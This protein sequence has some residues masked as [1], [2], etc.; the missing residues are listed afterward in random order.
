MQTEEPDVLTSAFGEDSLFRISQYDLHR[1]D[2]TVRII[3]RECLNGPQEGK[4]FAR[5]QLQLLSQF[6]EVWGEG[7]SEA[8]ALSQCV[9]NLKDVQI[10]KSI[11]DHDDSDPDWSDM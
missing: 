6:K 2:G 4:F 3:I 7:I 11:P 10:Q 8:Q 1:N 9:R 5:P